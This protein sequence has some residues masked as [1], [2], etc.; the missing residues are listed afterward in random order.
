MNQRVKIG[1]VTEVGIDTKEKGKL[2]QDKEIIKKGSGEKE[3]SSKQ[4]PAPQQVLE[5]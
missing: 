2:S 4:V 1:V 3:L 5:V